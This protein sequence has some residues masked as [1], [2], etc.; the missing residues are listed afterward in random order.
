MVVALVAVVFS[1]CIATNLY[2]IVTAHSN[3]KRD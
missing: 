3:D 2:G 1:A